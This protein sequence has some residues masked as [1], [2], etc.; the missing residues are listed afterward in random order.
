MRIDLLKH[1]IKVTAI[2]PGAAETEFSNVRFKGDD[3]RAAA[4]Y[5]GFVPL[6][7]NDIA[8]IVLYTAMLPAHVCINELIVT[9]TAQANPFYLYRP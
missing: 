9:P 3:A 8:D 5:K 4:V 7:A 6:T 1:K 2:H